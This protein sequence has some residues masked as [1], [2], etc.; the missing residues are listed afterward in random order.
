MDLN[1]YSLVASVFPGPSRWP[2]S[3]PPIVWNQMVVAGALPSKDG[4]T[5]PVHSGLGTLEPLSSGLRADPPQSPHRASEHNDH[6]Q[7]VLPGRYLD[8][9]ERDFYQLWLECYPRMGLGKMARAYTWWMNSPWPPSRGLK[10]LTLFQAY[11]PRVTHADIELLE[12]LCC[13]HESFIEWVEEK[14]L[15]LREV[16]F[17]RWSESAKTQQPEFW[18]KFCA[19]RP[20][21]AVGANILE[22]YFEITELGFVPA[23]R[24]TNM[25]AEAWLKSLQR[26]RYP[27]SLANDAGH[28]DKLQT[29]P[30][31]RAVRA[32]WVRQGDQSFAEI[33]MRVTSKADLATKIEGLRHVLEKMDEL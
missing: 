21:R 28:S 7:A 5:G 33:Q 1:P 9:S 24:E 2:A 29:L 19:L 32:N 30:W 22:L 6:T 14:E 11:Y 26:Q 25:S 31:P 13:T 15:G 3:F 18:E 4:V 20:S 27:N 16:Q 12:G 10:F 23:P 8:L 17:F